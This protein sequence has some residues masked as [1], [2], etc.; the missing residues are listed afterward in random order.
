MRDRA[1]VRVWLLA[2]VI[3]MGAGC[4]AA[5]KVEDVP[6]QGEDSAAVRAME[7]GTRGRAE[8][9]KEVEGGGGGQEAALRAQ[10]DR[11]SGKDLEV[12]SGGVR[13]LAAAEDRLVK[14]E[15]DL[16]SLRRKANSPAEARRAEQ[17]VLE[18]MQQ[19]L[20]EENLELESFLRMGQVIRH[21]PFLLQRLRDYLEDEEIGRFYGVEFG[22]S[23]P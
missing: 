14:E 17:Q 23:A 9:A 2:V 20:E 18:A 15:R 6:A 11:V 4:G 1:M 8:E 7:A 16:E 5:Q 19:A 13:A 12:F 21:N 22:E 3:F 10:A